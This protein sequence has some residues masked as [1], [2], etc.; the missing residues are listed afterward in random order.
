MILIVLD[1]HII[2]GIIIV[3]AILRNLLYYDSCTVEG[4]KQH[5][6]YCWPGVSYVLVQYYLNNSNNNNTVVI[7]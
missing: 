2:G 3:V 4:H 6:W 5:Y 1:A 7:V